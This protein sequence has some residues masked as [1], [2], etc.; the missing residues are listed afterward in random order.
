MFWRNGRGW[1]IATFGVYTATCFLSFLASFFISDFNDRCHSNA[2]LAPVFS[3]SISAL[4]FIFKSWKL[5]LLLPYYVSFGLH[6]GFIGFYV[7]RMIVAN[8]VGAG[9][10]G[11][12]SALAT[13][14]AAIL[15]FPYSKVSKKLSKYYVLIFGSLTFAFCGASLLFFTDSQVNLY[16]FRFGDYFASGA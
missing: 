5:A 11:I 15:A 6:S 4:K 16:F 3:E 1:K 8:Q 2:R 7:N 13:S 10:I 14:T 12:F 9:Y